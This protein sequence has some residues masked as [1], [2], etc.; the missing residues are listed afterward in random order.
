M[1][2]QFVRQLDS[3]CKTHAPL[4]EEWIDKGLA[5][6][7][8]KLSESLK[9]FLLETDGLYDYKQFLWIVWNVR[10][11]AAYNL[12]MRNDETFAARGYTFDDVFFFS[13]AGVGGILFGFPIVD[14]LIEEK[15]IAFYPANGERVDKAENLEA[16][17]LGWFQGS[18]KV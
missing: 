13:N 7:N 16:Y 15:I 3:N 12:A 5:E 8:V 17:L 1:W 11:L 2:L 18:L 14:G 4:S 9:S 6:L 10:D